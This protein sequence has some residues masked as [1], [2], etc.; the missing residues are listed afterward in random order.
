MCFILHYIEKKVLMINPCDVCTGY[1]IQA[2]RAPYR[3]IKEVGDFLS[4]LVLAADKVLIVV[5]LISTLIMKKMH[6]DQHS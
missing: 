5:I 2:T 3:L 6:K 1:C 4:E